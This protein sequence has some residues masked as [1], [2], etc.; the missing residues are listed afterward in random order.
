MPNLACFVCHKKV[1]DRLTSHD[2]VL[3]IALIAGYADNGH[4]HYALDCFEQM[5]LEGISPNVAAFV[6]ALQLAAP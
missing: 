4:G 3:W 6:Y 1:F 5:Q 2:V